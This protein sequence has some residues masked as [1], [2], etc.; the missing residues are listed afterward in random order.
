MLVW[1][2]GGKT[3]VGYRDPHRLDIDNASASV[4]PVLDKMSGLLE[5]LARAAAGDR[6]G[7]NA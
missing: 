4:R 1:A 6:S 5:R 7:V 2:Q 3:T